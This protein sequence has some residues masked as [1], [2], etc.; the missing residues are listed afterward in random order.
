M[1][2]LPIAIAGVVFL[3]QTAVQQPPRRLTAAEHAVLKQQVETLG[4]PLPVLNAEKIWSASDL[5][6][7]LLQMEDGYVQMY[8][9][10]AL[11][12]LEDPANV[13][14]LLALAQRPDISKSF[15]GRA[16]AQSLNGFD[17][18]QDAELIEEAATFLRRIIYLENLPRELVIS[19][20]PAGM[21][22]Y[23]TPDQVHAVESEIVRL[24]ERTQDLR[25]RFG[26]YLSAARALESLAR[27][28]SRVTPFN[29]ETVRRLSRMVAGTWLNDNPSV[30]RAAFAALTTQRIDADTERRALRDGD[31]RLATVVL[32]GS[33]GGLEGDERLDAIQDRLSDDDPQVRYEALRGYVRLSVRTR[34]CQPVYDLLDDRDTHVA[35]AAIDAFGTICLDD[36]EITKRFQADAKVPPP[37]GPWHRDTHAFVTLAKRDREAGAALLEPFVTHQNFWV[38]M[39]AVQAAV[40]LDRMETLNK[41]AYDKHP[42]VRE[43]AL[44]NMAQLQ[45]PETFDAAIVALGDND[46]QLV[47]T[48]ALVLKQFPSDPKAKETVLVALLRLT[49]EQK[50]TSRDARLPLLETLALNADADDARSIM[51]LL[52]DIDPLVASAAGDLITKLTGKPAKVEPTPVA[53]GWP[54]Q[55]PD[56]RKQCVAVAMSTGRSFVMRMSLATPLT[57]DRFLKLA[58]VDRY[59]DGLPFHRVLPNFVIQGGSPGANEY[60]GQQLFM[61]DEIGARHSAGTVGLSTRGRNTA[62]GQFFINLV[63]NP[64]LDA[65]Y[66]VF[67]SVVEGMTAVA[68]IQEGDVMSRFSAVRC[69]LGR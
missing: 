13:R 32:G 22:R 9:L 12:R 62:D 57:V 39:Y 51:P 3:A 50:E 47:R 11:G 52:K 1:M 60:S 29:P 68:A 63:E 49:K 43:A 33:G 19:P 2:K 8:T 53:R 5:L 16:I 17:P 46:I 54:I 42:N 18:S 28:N 56:L 10:R 26:D 67:A 15:V 35:L 44:S 69:P 37:N 48:A 14:T 55:F 45:R 58:L 21:V 24:L 6:W 59:Y 27:L 66:T 41:L 64:Q 34:G 40:A 7:P 31:R 61:R 20:E 36:E 4:E 30:R 38:R 23:H 25:T 65:D